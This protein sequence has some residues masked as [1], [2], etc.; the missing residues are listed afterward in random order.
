M[1]VPLPRRRRHS[2]RSAR[3]RAESLKGCASPNSAMSSTHRNSVGTARNVSRGKKKSLDQSADTNGLRKRNERSPINTIGRQEIEGRFESQCFG[4]P[5]RPRAAFSK[6]TGT[7]YGEGQE[8]RVRRKRRTE[9]FRRLF[10]PGIAS[11]PA[12]CSD[13]LHCSHSQDLAPSLHKNQ[14]T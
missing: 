11:L 4:S 10:L 3:F 7:C 6:S 1:P 13:R 12:E 5:T 2:I 8:T 9:R 14:P